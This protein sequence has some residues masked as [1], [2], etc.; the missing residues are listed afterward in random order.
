[1]PKPD[2]S[3]I[4]ACGAHKIYETI[5]DK[6]AFF[7]KP[8]LNSLVLLSLIFSQTSLLIT[9]SANDAGALT[10]NGNIVDIDYIVPDRS[11]NTITDRAPNNTPIVYI[12]APTND[13]ISLNNFADFNIHSENLILNNSSELIF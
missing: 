11:T 9:I 6:F 7:I 12:A 5:A 4:F 1:M 13:G 10:A 8:I 2:L 3:K